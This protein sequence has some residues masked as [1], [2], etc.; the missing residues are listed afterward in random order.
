MLGLLLAAAAVTFDPSSASDLKLDNAVI[1]RETFKNVRSLRV[2]P[3][4]RDP[5]HSGL[6]ALPLPP[7]HDGS[8]ELELAGDVAPDA[9]AGARGFVG[10]AFRLQPDNR[11]EC[12]YLRP[13][14]GRADDQLR[15]NHSLQY[16]SEPDYP[17]ER[18]RQEAPG[19]YESYADLQAGAW[20][21][22]RIEVSGIKARLY[23][24]GAAQP[25]LIVKELKRGDSSGAIG[26]WVG[27]GS[28]GHFS[29]LRVA[30]QR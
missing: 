21:R 1:A 29:M 9:D 27:P 14:N 12:F 25:A 5:N 24:N 7:V 19:V 28:I 18:L 30:A 26:L 10:I 6:V 8:I 11:Y 17:W 20:T 2:E 23:V 22:V 15:R 13:T 3:A 16:V 4:T